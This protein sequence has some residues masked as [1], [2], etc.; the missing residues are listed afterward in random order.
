[1]KQRGCRS[2]PV[3]R[4][5]MFRKCALPDITWQMIFLIWSVIPQ[6]YAT[7]PSPPRAACSPLCLSRGGGHPPNR[8][9]YRIMPECEQQDAQERGRY[10]S[11]GLRMLPACAINHAPPRGSSN[12]ISFIFLIFKKIIEDKRIANFSASV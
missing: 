12:H 8:R 4:G 2:I 1:M 5:V 11:A 6:G 9:G 7:S 10:H 3:L